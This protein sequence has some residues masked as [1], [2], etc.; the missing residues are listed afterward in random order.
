MYFLTYAPMFVLTLLLG[1]VGWELT[2][3]ETVIGGY[4]PFAAIVLGP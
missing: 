2:M 3:E 4:G 1:L